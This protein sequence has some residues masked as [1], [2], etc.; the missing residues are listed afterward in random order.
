MAIKLKET[1]TGKL[2]IV[3]SREQAFVFK[4]LL[5][6]AIHFTQSEM[7]SGA[8]TLHKAKQLV[9]LSM[10]QEVYKKHLVK[11]SITNSKVKLSIDK[12]QASIIW[13]YYIKTVLND[14]EMIMEDFSDL[15]EM[16]DGIH[17]KLS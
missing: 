5:E 13:I 4:S 7:P 6:S 2:N 17:K 16:M 9:Y 12:G 1:P 15:G 11:L 3:I 8:L 14:T 10:L